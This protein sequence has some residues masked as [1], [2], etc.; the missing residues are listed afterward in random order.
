MVDTPFVD[1]SLHVMLAL[2]MLMFP[3]MRRQEQT[4]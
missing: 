2:M 3:S 1:L 4:T